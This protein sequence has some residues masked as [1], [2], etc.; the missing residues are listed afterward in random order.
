MKKQT[1]NMMPLTQGAVRLNKRAKTPA[2]VRGQA[3]AGGYV[4]HLGLGE[5]RLVA[6]AA[7]DRGRHGER[8]KLL[9]MVLFDACLRVS[10]APGLRPRDLKQDPA[11]WWKLREPGNSALFGWPR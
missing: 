10:E 5:V 4:P 2:I 8:D 1:T 11:R 9:V 3:E 7:G 6:E